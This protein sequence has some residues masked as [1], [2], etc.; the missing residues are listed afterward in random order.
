MVQFVDI[1]LIGKCYLETSKPERYNFY[2][3]MFAYVKWNM[4]GPDA[5]VSVKTSENHFDS[6]SSCLEVDK[7][8]GSCE[9]HAS[10]Q[11]ISKVANAEM[12]EFVE[13]SA[14]CAE[15]WPGRPGRVTQPSRR[16]VWGV[17]DLAALAGAK[18]DHSTEAFGSHVSALRARE[19]P[20]PRLLG[21][22]Q[23][24]RHDEQHRCG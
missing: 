10:R 15:C 21:I 4:G 18:G 13:I 19:E 23:Q 11:Q 7:R 9:R 6:T 16:S 5:R 12:A 3:S 17:E 22:R 1:F 2:D 20:V 8:V 14:R 24:H